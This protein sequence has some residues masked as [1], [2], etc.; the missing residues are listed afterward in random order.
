[1]HCRREQVRRGIANIPAN[2]RARSNTVYTIQIPDSSNHRYNFAFIRLSASSS[3]FARS[4]SS[5]RRIFPAALEKVR[6]VRMSPAIRV[7]GERAHLFGIESTT[8]T[9]EDGYRVSTRLRQEGQIPTATQ[10]LVSR[11]AGFDP[12][13]HLLA[14]RLV[15]LRLET[16]RMNDVRAARSASGENTG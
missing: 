5:R 15:F 14:E 16:P 3:A 2:G 10:E 8:T 9:P 13:L 11:N 6:R 4:R 7:V 12:F 1:M